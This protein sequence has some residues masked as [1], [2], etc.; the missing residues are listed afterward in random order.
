MH[1]T[2]LQVVIAILSMSKEKQSHM[3]MGLPRL[4]PGRILAMT[5]KYDK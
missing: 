5:R 1:E 2:G 3:N 4:R